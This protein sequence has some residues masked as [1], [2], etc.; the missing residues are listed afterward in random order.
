MSLYNE[1]RPTDLSQVKGQEKVVAQI[2][3][4]LENGNVPNVSLFVGPRGTGKTTVARIFSKGINCKS[5][6]G[7]G[8]CNQCESCQSITGGNSIDVIELDAASHNKVDDVHQ[9]IESVAYSPLSKYKV[10][11]IDEVHMLSQA[12]FNAL[13]KLLEEPPVYCKFILCTTEEHKVPVTIMSRCRKFYFERIELSVVAEKMAAIC[14]DRNISY[15]EDALRI[16]AKRSEGCMRDAESLLEIF[17]DSGNVSKNSVSNILGTSSEDVIFSILEGIANG[18]VIS[19]LSA[20]KDTA[21]KGKDL[22]VLLKS[23]IEA[24]TDTAYYIQSKDT[25]LLDNSDS[26]INRV[27]DY[28]AVTDENSCFH[29]ITELT[30]IFSVV[31]KGGSIDFVLEAKLISLIGSKSKISALEKDIDFLKGKCEALENALYEGFST[32]P[33]TTSEQPQ[34]EKSIAEASFSCEDEVSDS[35]LESFESSYSNE[36]SE[37]EDDS[38]FTP[39]SDAY[40]VLPGDIS[41]PEG[42]QVMGTISLFEPKREKPVPASEQGITL[43]GFSSVEEESEEIPFENSHVVNMDNGESV[44]EAPAPAKPQEQKST[45]VLDSFGTN[46]FEGLMDIPGVKGFFT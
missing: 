4:I 37:M 10:Y 14:K 41:L 2:R 15:E 3:A 36:E 16:I 5:P 13:L 38:F 12:A 46:F 29:M 17:L 23:L 39:P 26:Y 31:Q 9:I 27:I 44:A 33:I 28:A 24:L 1:V 42:T 25:S 21:S 6:S 18:N 35:S 20:I 7:N 22:T 19:I 30:D 40:D 34:V 32:R 11:I 45:D 43:S 8:P